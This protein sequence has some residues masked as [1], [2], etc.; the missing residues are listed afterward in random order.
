MNRPRP[1]AAS[2]SRWVRVMKLGGAYARGVSREL[3]TFDGRGGA[4]AD[5]GAYFGF[6]ASTTSRSN[7][8]S[9]SMKSTQSDAASHPET[10]RYAPPGWSMYDPGPSLSCAL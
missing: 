3:P 5:A 8:P 4:R 6:G 10:W 7:G 2:V 9:L 1:V